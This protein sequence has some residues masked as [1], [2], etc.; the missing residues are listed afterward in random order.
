[1]DLTLNQIQVG[2]AVH[3]SRG[4]KCP[5]DDYRTITSITPDRSAFCVTV[6]GVP[7]WILPTQIRAAVRPDPDP[8]A[9]PSS[10]ID[11]GRIR[12]KL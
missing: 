7:R 8:T 6:L 12:S 2:D 1:M 9:I 10:I 11:I 4:T 5:G 3:Y